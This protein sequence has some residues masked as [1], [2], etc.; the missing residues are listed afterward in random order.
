MKSLDKRLT[1]MEAE[2]IDFKESIPNRPLTD[3]EFEELKKHVSL[4]D[5]LTDCTYPDDHTPSPINQKF[6]IECELRGIHL[7]L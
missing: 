5:I 4:F 6:I 1:K 3:E 2:S 7:F